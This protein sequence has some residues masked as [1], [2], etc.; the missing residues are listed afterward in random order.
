MVKKQKKIIFLILVCQVIR[1]THLG[2][3][4]KKS[5]Q[6]SIHAQFY[7]AVKGPVGR[8]LLQL[9]TVSVKPRKSKF[10]TLRRCGILGKPLTD[11]H[12]K[13][14]ARTHSD[15][16]LWHGRLQLTMV[17]VTG[18]IGAFTKVSVLAPSTGVLAGIYK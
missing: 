7:M 18:H 4:L 17:N 8:F 13:K 2:R 14:R 3:I 15:R 1:N 6:G 11:R 10:P 5:L 16:H 9:C 12:I